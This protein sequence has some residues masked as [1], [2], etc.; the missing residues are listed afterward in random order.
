MDDVLLMSDPAAMETDGPAV[1]EDPSMA[2]ILGVASCVRG[3]GGGAGI[4]TVQL[5]HLRPDLTVPHC[6]RCTS[7]TDP[8]T[9]IVPDDCLIG[10]ESPTPRRPLMPMQLDAAYTS[11]D[12]GTLPF[13]RFP[14][15]THTHTHH[16]LVTFTH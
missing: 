9:E 15:P 3:G 11:S 1:L 2:D 14:P 16:E 8:K 5:R 4:A 13:V 12:P 10:V 6:H 7:A